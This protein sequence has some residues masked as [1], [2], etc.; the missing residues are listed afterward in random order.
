MEENFIVTAGHDTAKRFLA[1]QMRREMTP[2]ERLFW[3]HLRANRLGGLH[4]RRQQMAAFTKII[5]NMMP[6]ATRYYR[7]AGYTSFGSRTAN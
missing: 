6:S 3:Q 1:L 5:R 7:L 4:F 2:S